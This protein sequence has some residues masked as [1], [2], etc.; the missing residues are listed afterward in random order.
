VGED[1]L[2]AGTMGRGKSGVLNVFMAALSQCA[3]VVL[4]AST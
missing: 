3:D 4:W 1:V 2:I